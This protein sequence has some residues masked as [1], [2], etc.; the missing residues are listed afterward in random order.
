M[1]EEERS[2]DDMVV[3]RLGDWKNDST[4]R[5]KD[6]SREEINLGIQKANTVS[7]RLLSR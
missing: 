7:D 5:G 6:K 2:K 4:M 1:N 3:R